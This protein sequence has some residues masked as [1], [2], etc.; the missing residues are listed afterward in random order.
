[1][2]PLGDPADDRYVLSVTYG[3]RG[4]KAGM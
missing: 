3:F 1:V 2:T 4:T